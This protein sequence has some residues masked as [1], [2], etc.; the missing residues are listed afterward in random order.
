MPG[1]KW[2]RRCGLTWSRCVRPAPP[3]GR[4]HHTG[5]HDGTALKFVPGRHPNSGDGTWGSSEE[6]PSFLYAMPLGGKRV[7]LEETCLVAKPALP[8]AVLKRRLTRRLK[9]MGISVTKVCAERG[10]EGR[11]GGREGRDSV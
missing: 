3:R 7:F 4:R 1:G 6:C 11:E 8:F 10:G 9:A 2:W 5:L